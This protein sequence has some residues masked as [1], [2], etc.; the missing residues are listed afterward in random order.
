MFGQD[1]SLFAALGIAGLLAEA[2]NMLLTA[3]LLG[4]ELFGVTSGAYLL[5]TCTV[6]FLLSGHRNAIP[7][8]LLQLH[9][10]PV[11]QA[12]INEEIGEEPPSR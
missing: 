9:K 12:K 7:T 11:L 6:A 8:Q 10:A 5:L 1:P 3:L 4:L 2:I